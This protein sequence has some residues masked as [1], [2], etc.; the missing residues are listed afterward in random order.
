MNTVTFLPDH[1]RIAVEPGTTILAAARQA[2]VLIEAPC[3]GAGHCGKCAVRVAPDYLD[4][5]TIPPGTHLPPERE[6]AGWLLACHAEVQGDITVTIPARSENGLQIVTTGQHRRSVALSPWITKR[7]NP[8][9]YQTLVYAG[10]RL[11]TVERGDTAVDAYGVVVDIGTTTLVV[12]LVDLVSGKELASASALNP[13]SLHAQDVLSRIRFSADP[14]GLAQMQSELITE[15][16][17]LITETTA[18]AGVSRMWL[19]EA[20]FSGNTCMLHLAAGVDPAPLGKYPFTPTLTGGNHL[21]AADLGL[22]IAPKG[23]VYLPPVIS[24][25]VGADITAGILAA[26]LKD[27][28]GTTLF[29]DIGTNGEMILANDGLL[30]ATSTAAG[31]AFEGMNISC[32]MRAAAGAIEEVRITADGEVETEVIGKVEAIGI[33]G[34]GLMDLVAELV[35]TGVIGATGK[36]TA[37]ER[38]PEPLGTRLEKE[39]GSTQFR[40]TETISLSQKDVRQVQL[41]KGAIRAGIDILLDERGVSAAGLDRVYI[42]GSFG[43]HLREESLLTL[44]LLP[45]ECAGKVSFL[46]NTSQSGGE[47][48]LLSDRLRV[49][50]E[51]LT[52][53]VE[54]VELTGRADF[55]R[56][57]MKAMGF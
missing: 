26:E 22:S 42:A 23:L 2:G 51:A 7:F 52:A 18:T 33:C 28:S 21:K 43:F 37:A 47:L 3:N 27:L 45:I 8:E 10:E 35:R 48:L 50:L 53:D 41:A 57:F 11:L 16:N 38:L 36:F 1:I 32:G 34:S 4:H 14:G 56:V 29:I 40:V 15:L 54:R 30:A 31:P 55:D 5:L 39:N 19:Y 9:T 13:Q 20:V 6:A 46:G 12:A 17:R 44:G 25:Y 49:E 24:A